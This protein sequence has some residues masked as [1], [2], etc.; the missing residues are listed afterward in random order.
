MMEPKSAVVLPS[1]PPRVHTVLIHFRTKAE[2]L[3]S[4]PN[5]GDENVVS[6][7]IT[8]RWHLPSQVLVQSV[9]VC[10]ANGRHN[11]MSA[12]L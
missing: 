10:I 7:A 1:D 5:A 11:T 3:V 8:R 4:L 9:M 6:E 2:K 12:R